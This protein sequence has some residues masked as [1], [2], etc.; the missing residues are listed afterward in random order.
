MGGEGGGV[1]GA[2]LTHRVASRPSDVSPREF[3]RPRGQPY[4]LETKYSDIPNPRLHTSSVTFQFTC[5]QQRLGGDRGIGFSGGGRK[6]VQNETT[7]E[8]YFFWYLLAVGGSMGC[9]WHSDE[10]WLDFSLPPLSKIHQTPASLDLTFVFQQNWC[11]ALALRCTATNISWI[12]M[13]SFHR[14]TQNKLA[15]LK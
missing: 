3:C 9:R 10:G 5:M 8:K 13:I 7:G 1:S 2:P 6:R 11:P 4:T 15:K 12:E 14:Q